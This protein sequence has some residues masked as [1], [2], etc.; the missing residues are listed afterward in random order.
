MVEP[1]HLRSGL[2]I[3]PTDR[4]YIERAVWLIAGLVLLVATGLA[5]LVEPWWVLAIIGVGLASINVAVTG[6]CIVGNGL[7]LLGFT[8]MLGTRAPTR[9][10]LYFMQTDRWYLERRIYLAVGINISL[11]SVLVLAHSVWWLLFT[12][13]VGAAM[14]WFAATGFCI[15]ANSLYWLG[16]EPRLVPEP[17]PMPAVALSGP[18]AQV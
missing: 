4:W 3:V 7:R 14:V 15:M 2:Y 8:P 18:P 12:G 13:F 9:W 1:M 6:F 11:A 5:A 16:A 10:N 17:R